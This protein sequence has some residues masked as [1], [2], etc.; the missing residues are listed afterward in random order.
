ML[1]GIEIV[2][3]K[4]KENLIEEYVHLRNRYAELLL[5]LPVNVSATKEWIKKNDDVEVRG[6]VQNNILLGVA[7]LYLNRGGEVAFFAKEQQKGIGSKLLKIIEE[8]AREK[9]LKGVW[10]WVLS[11]NTVA[12]KSFMKNGYL[13]EQKTQRRYNDK[14]LEG[15]IFRKKLI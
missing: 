7:I 5:T 4:E 9:K 14:N 13:S 2:D 11:S 10:A 6:L 3:L 8:V 12:Q 15:F 1:N